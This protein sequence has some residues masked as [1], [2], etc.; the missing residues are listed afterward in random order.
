[1]CSLSGSANL[2][3][4]VKFV[5]DQPLLPWQRKF[6][7]FNSKF[8]ITQLIKEICPRFLHQTGGF[9]LKVLNFRY[10][11]NRGWSKTNF[12]ATIK[13]ADPENP[14]WCKNQG[15]IS[16]I[17]RVIANF[18][19]KFSHFRCHGNRGW[20]STNFTSTVKFADPDNPY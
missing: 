1:M 19:L 18:L 2:S 14:V 10:H 7:N 8:A 5:P 12:T 3:V 16:C 4:Q 9:L 11:G 20:S 13:L 6:E 15:H 17:S